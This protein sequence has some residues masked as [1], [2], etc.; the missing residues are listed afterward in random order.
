MYNDKVDKHRMLILG[1]E[2]ILIRILSRVYD[3]YQYYSLGI[4]GR[5]ALI[6]EP[7]TL[8]QMAED[9]VMDRFLGDICDVAYICLGNRFP[10][11][12]CPGDICPLMV[13]PDFFDVLKIKVIMVIQGSNDS[14]I[15]NKIVRVDTIFH[16]WY[17]VQ[18]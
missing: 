13:K 5:V 17:Q 10:S 12:K 14:V 9:Q 2:V 18:Y 4:T 7:M 11:Y 8:G 1:I 6:S 3:R 15:D 16:T